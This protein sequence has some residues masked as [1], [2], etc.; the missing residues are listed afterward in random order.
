MCVCV[1][2]LGG[3]RATNCIASDL[4]SSLLGLLFGKLKYWIFVIQFGNDVSYSLLFLTAIIHHISYVQA[5][6]EKAL[7]VF[8][9]NLLLKKKRKR[10]QWSALTEMED[11]KSLVAG[12]Q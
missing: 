3:G 9:E 4:Q 8:V 7:P 12:T 2:V 6:Q 10:S 1:C 11:W 5:H